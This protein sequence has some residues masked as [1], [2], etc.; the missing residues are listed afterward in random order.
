MHKLFLE[1]A[2]PHQMKTDDHKHVDLRLV[3]TQRLVI[4]EM[5]SWCQPIQE[6]KLTTQPAA[7]SLTLPLKPLP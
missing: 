5:S 4:L 6:H 1:E 2:D 7:P 3:K